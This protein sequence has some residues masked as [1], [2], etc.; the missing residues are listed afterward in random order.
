MKSKAQLIKVILILIVLIFIIA[1]CYY[2]Y[3]NSK[4]TQKYSETKNLSQEN[5]FGKIEGSLI[6]P[7]D[8]PIIEMLVCAKEI[9]K[10]TSYC[11]AEFIEDQKY[12]NGIGYVLELP[13]GKYH[14]YSIY[15]LDNSKAFYSEYVLCGLKEECKSHKPVE[16][17]VEK[18]KVIQGI[19][20]I[21]WISE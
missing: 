6:P 15:S 10:Q 8:V 19:D 16:I 13:I 17:T 20:P 4:A 21:D 7:K 18:E 11:T 1:F 12:K 5:Q 14:V 9:T 3:S 2:L